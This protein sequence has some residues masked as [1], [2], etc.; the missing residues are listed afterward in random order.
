MNQR[1]SLSKKADSKNS[2]MPAFSRKTATGP[3]FSRQDPLLQLQRQLGN[4][5]LQHMYESGQLKAKLKRG[6]PNDK[7]EQKDDPVTWTRESG[8]ENLKSQISNS[9]SESSIGRLELN[10]EEVAQSPAVNPSTPGCSGCQV[11]SSGTRYRVPI[12]SLDSHQVGTPYADM[13]RHGNNFLNRNSLRRQANLSAP[14]RASTGP[15]KYSNMAAPG[16]PAGMFTAGHFLFFAD[17]EICETSRNPCILRQSEVITVTRDGQAPRRTV[18]RPVTPL[19]GNAWTKAARIN[20]IGACDKTLVWVDGPGD[21]AITGGNSPQGFV[22]DVTQTIEILDGGTN[23]VVDTKTIS[24]S[25][26]VD[27]RGNLTASP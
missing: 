5:T 6:A 23:Q 21:I 3:S 1:R 17:W 19:Q 4:A 7:Y 26:G 14:R 16:I 10:P 25:V 11:C 24:I 2:V 18:H 12:A 27:S 8:A 20:P 13:E 22:Q 9:A 15:F